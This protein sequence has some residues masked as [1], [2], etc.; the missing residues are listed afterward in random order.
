MLNVRIFSNSEGNNNFFIIYELLFHI[1]MISSIFLSYWII[2]NKNISKIENNEK[3]NNY[4][5]RK[6]E[7]VI[8]E[9]KK[10]NFS[11]IIKGL[12]KES[13]KGKW[14]SIYDEEYED[15]YIFISFKK[16]KNTQL[17]TEIR[18]IKK[19]YLTNWNRIIG[20]IEEYNLEY[21]E[22]NNIIEF[23]ATG[24]KVNVESGKII[25]S[26]YSISDCF[27]D[28]ELDFE[29]LENN[30]L[31][32]KQI[33]GNI[34][35]MCKDISNSEI[36][37]KKESYINHFLIFF[38]SSILIVGLNNSNTFLVR[39]RFDEVFA[40][41]ISL[42]TIYEN[43]RHY[44][45]FVQLLFIFIIDLKKY[46][47]LFWI[48]LF[49]NYPFID[50]RFFNLIWRI[51]YRVQLS[52]PN[53]RKKIM[54]KSMFS[55]FFF[56]F[57]SL[58]SVSRFYF[59]KE[60]MLINSILT[61]FPQIIYNIIYKN[62]ISIPYSICF[63]YF[64]SKFYI[65]IYFYLYKDNIL[66]IS[67]NIKLIITVFLIYLFSFLILLS[68]QIFGPRW[69][70]P[71]QKRKKVRNI[72]KF[73]NE[74]LQIKPELIN[75][76]CVICLNPLFKQENEIEKEKLELTQDFNNPRNIEKKKLNERYEENNKIKISWR[77]FFLSLFE[78]Q[79]KNFKFINSP[80]IFLECHHCFHFN[81][82]L[83]WI[84]KKKLCPI[85]RAKI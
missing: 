10:N 43:I 83:S 6:L 4:K 25:N 41:G 66:I 77:E 40:N 1:I 37:I 8:D 64:I 26:I 81:C 19:N 21:N 30:I 3:I 72:F 53:T 31:N 59:T 9:E 82:V 78:F 80:Y 85:C 84:K 47:F 75:E 29:I 32:F 62:E 11:L 65:I 14:K 18:Q 58:L 51:K 23:K 39:N 45:C 48:V 16:Y 79:D 74:I 54:C 20:Y 2:N 17:K 36:I 50:M 49:I 42:I 13:Y 73:K 63:T 15:N 7:D 68:Q 35:S 76:D 33:K 34:Y 67:K 55:F 71:C 28:L 12:T 52:N 27:L 38:I 70:I 24:F 5:E 44:L 61:F 57:F 46:I 60:N 22:E 56:T 69:F